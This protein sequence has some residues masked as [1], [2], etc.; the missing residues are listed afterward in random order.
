LKLKE[1]DLSAC[2]HRLLALEGAIQGVKKQL[3]DERRKKELKN[4]F[5]LYRLK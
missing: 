2:S 1:I 4:F 3:I 5:E